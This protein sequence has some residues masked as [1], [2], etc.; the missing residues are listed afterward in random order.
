MARAEPFHCA[1][2]GHQIGR[3]ST[4]LLIDGHD[5]VTCLRCAASPATHA[6]VYPG[7][8]DATHTIYDHPPR[9]HHATRAGARWW[10]AQR[11]NAVGGTR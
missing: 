8:P 5:T 10:L 9:R 4:H 3:Q 6:R 11:A 2:C 7:C 1:T